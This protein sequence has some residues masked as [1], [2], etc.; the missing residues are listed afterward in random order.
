MLVD[1]FKK[2]RNNSLKNYGVCPSHYLSAPA[3]SWDVMLNMAKVELEPIPDPDTYY[4]SEKGMKGGVSYISK[5]Y[6]KASKKYLKSY[7]PQQESKHIIYL[8]VSRLYG[9]VRSKFLPTSLFKWIDPKKL[10]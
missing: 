4:F 3:L 5:R 2:F 6:S 10:E 8:D 9:Y 7:D 1:V